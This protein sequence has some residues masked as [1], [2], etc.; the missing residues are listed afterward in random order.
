MHNTIH[1]NDNYTLYSF[2][3]YIPEKKIYE[4]FISIDDSKDTAGSLLYKT[5][6]NRLLANLYYK[7]LTYLIINKK[8]IKLEKIIENR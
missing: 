5:F 8:P 7:V 2:L 6:K 1:S 3:N 4:A